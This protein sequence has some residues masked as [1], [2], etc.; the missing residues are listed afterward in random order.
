MKKLRPVQWII[1]GL[2]LLT[3]CGSPL[4]TATA[5]PPPTVAPRM[6]VVPSPTR[7]PS[8][9]MTVAPPTP[10]AATRPTADVSWLDEA[11][12]SETAFTIPL[13]TRHVTV[14]SAT[15]Q[16][17]LTESETA[18]LFVWPADSASEPQ[19]WPLGERADGLITVEGLTTG[20]RYQAAL[21]VGEPMARPIF[22][23]T[24]W[25]EISFSTQSDRGF[26]LRIAVIGDS[27]FGDATTEA[28]AV[29]MVAADP[30]LVLHTGDLVYRINE[31]PDAPT[32]FIE[33]LF[34]PF[35]PVLQVGPFY[36]VPGNHDLE[37]AARWGDSTYYFTAF[38][39]L[40]GGGVETPVDSQGG[41]YS[42]SY[43]DI[44]FVMLNSQAVFGAGGYQAETDWLAE[45]V[46]EPAFRA[47]IIVLHVPPR[48]AGRHRTDSRIIRSRWG[49]LLSAPG[50]VL[51]LAGH[52]HNYQR[53]E[54]DGVVTLVTG[55]GS[56]TLYSINSE[57]DGLQLAAR[58]SHF[59]LLDI[60]ETAID[61]SAI[62]AAGM[63][64]D[65]AR[66]QLPGP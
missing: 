53:F 33:K 3:A 19:R 34:K 48:N 30:D 18:E 8:P 57:A 32:A 51:V 9:T 37:A 60:G 66:V 41:W 40:D 47:T 28:L 26:P 22:E 20:T 62:D 10:T 54:N 5:S 17:A 14:D 52:D 36:P 65:E 44:Q 55:G 7:K 1:A 56:Q 35:A 45:R 24:I 21:L 59:T 31:N 11:P 23:K 43:G 63:V 64:F 61:V 25:P 16:F 15:L 50:V 12:A 38:P 6:T 49:D 58:R 46:A 4:P 42:F 29:E 2:M 39:R 13:M 27:G